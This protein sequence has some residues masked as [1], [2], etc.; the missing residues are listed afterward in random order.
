MAKKKPADKRKLGG[1]FLAAAVFCENILEDMQRRL[2]VQGVIDGIQLLLPPFVP[3]DVPSE[4]HPLHLNQQLLLIFRSG[5]SPGEHDLKLELENPSGKRTVI[6]EQEVNLSEQ[7]NGG[8]NIKIAI[9]AGITNPAGGLYMVDVFLDG[10]LMTRVPL[11]LTITRS[12]MPGKADLKEPG[13]K[14]KG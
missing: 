5:D 9:T 13:S 11:M 1:P 6:K 7:K 4:E 2:T 3:D 8:V 14:K 12:E 10:K